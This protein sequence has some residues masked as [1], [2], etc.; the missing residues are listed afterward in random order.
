MTTF[1]RWAVHPQA[2]NVKQHTLST[3]NAPEVQLKQG[4]LHE[5]LGQCFKAKAVP[6]ATPL[7]PAMI[8]RMDVTRCVSFV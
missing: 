4:N 1:V 5:L 3:E 6:S 8:W 2:K 7:E